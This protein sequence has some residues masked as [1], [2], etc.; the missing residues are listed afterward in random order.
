MCLGVGDQA[1][2]ECT[3]QTDPAHRQDPSKEASIEGAIETQAPVS[4]GLGSFCTA[5]A[6][7]LFFSLHRQAQAGVQGLQGTGRENQ[8]GI[9]KESPVAGAGE[10]QSMAKTS[11]NR[12]YSALPY[13]RLGWH[14]KNRQSLG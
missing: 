12:S 2:P 5:G 1:S 8:M 11:R 9:W 13:S 3:F 14:P 6:D 10:R 4:L 7:T